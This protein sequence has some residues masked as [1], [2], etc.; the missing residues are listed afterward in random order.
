MALVREVTVEQE[1]VTGRRGTGGHVDKM[2]FQRPGVMRRR[3]IRQQV[4]WEV[5]SREGC[6]CV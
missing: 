2:L 6:S 3:E 5:N 4:E 1:D